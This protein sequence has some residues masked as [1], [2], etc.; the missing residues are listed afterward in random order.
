MADEAEGL[1]VLQHDLRLSR[2]PIAAGASGQQARRCRDGPESGRLAERGCSASQ[3][4]G[5][6][7]QKSGEGSGWHVGCSDAT[8][9][10][11]SRVKRSGL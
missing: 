2:R 10:G 6:G 3:P 11:L 4:T 1:L 9:A 5:R 8:V 7:P